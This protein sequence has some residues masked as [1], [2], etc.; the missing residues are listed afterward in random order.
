MEDAIADAYSGEFLLSSDDGKR[1][2]VTSV[3]ALNHEDVGIRLIAGPTE[4]QDILSGHG[5]EPE[6]L[7][8]II[9]HKEAPQL[10][11]LISSDL[12]ADRIDY[13]LRTARHTG[14][15]YGSVDLD[16]LLAMLALDSQNRICLDPR[17]MRTAEHLLFARYFDYQQV[18]YHKTV[19]AFEELL[20]SSLKDLI[21]Q[22]PLDCSKE[23]IE[24]AVCDP[25][26]WLCFDD[27]RIWGMIRELAGG[28]GGEPPVLRAKALT[29]RR[30][31]KLV[32]W[33]EFFSLRND[34]RRD[35][36]DLLTQVKRA[37]PVT[38]SVGSIDESLVWVW[39][40]G[41]KAIT[42]LGSQVFL[43]E[44]GEIDPEEEGLAVRILASDRSS[45][46]LVEM[47]SSL[48]SVLSNYS[49]GVVRLYALPPDPEPKGW[50][51]RV[52]SAVASEIA[53][54]HWTPAA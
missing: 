54:Y 19:V 37:V 33:A 7:A 5:V 6:M 30:G 25:D 17:A 14:L 28:G 50:R 8:A 32:G 4:I 47:E 20:K 31:P 13:L 44:R 23:T 53:S 24:A 40:S 2:G 16:Y 29:R 38:A 49:L 15:P 35:L 12:D 45:R 11:N 26:E 43:S 22:G 10:A 21:V 1:S 34:N 27:A 9:G 18:A 51:Q 42:T 52:S 3:N 46:P 36:L 48:L 41:S 39:S